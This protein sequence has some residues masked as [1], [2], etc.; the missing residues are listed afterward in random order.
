MRIRFSS[1]FNILLFTH[2]KLVASLL[3]RVNIA[4]FLMIENEIVLFISDLYFYHPGLGSRNETFIG[5]VL[6]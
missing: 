3:K 1:K 5:M 6:E 2:L 4:S